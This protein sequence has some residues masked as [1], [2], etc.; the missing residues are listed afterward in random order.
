M[1]MTSNALPAASAEVLSEDQD[2]RTA[3]IA[4][5]SMPP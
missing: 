4:Q 3:E 1:C 5:D 2:A